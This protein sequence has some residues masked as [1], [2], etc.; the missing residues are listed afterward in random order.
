[1]PRRFILALSAAVL[2]AFSLQ[3]S[4]APPAPQGFLMQFEWKSD[5][6]LFGGFSAIDISQDGARVTLITDRGAYGVGHITRDAQ[7]QISAVDLAPLRMLRGKGKDPLSKGRNDSEGLAIAADGTVYISFEGVARVLRYSRLDGEADNLPNHPDFAKLQRNSA[8]EA[9]A[10]D[11]QGTLYTLP[12]R[13]GGLDTPFKIYRYKNG[14]WDTPF[15]LPREPGY[16]P[17]GADVGP[18]GRLYILLRH[19]LGISG[20]SSKLIRMEL[21]ASSLGPPEV[22]FQSPT[23]FHDNLEGVS[24]WR[25]RAGRLRATMVADNNFV[26]FLSSGIV[27]YALPD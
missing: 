1:M 26:P 11:A 15:S 17:V 10:I 12:E 23:G 8:L 4:A 3:S 21:G 16:L 24:V 18:D 19:F 14:V 13:S 6:P 27:E 25:D 22:M 20:F 7:G 5:D 2:A 9:L